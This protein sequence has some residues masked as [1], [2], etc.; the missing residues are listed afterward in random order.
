MARYRV[1]K[2]DGGYFVANRRSGKIYGWYP[3]SKEKAQAQAASME[4]WFSNKPRR[5]TR[6]TQYLCRKCGEKVATDAEDEK[7]ARRHFHTRA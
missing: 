5:H 6:W 4:T 3:R 1:I 7:A 2:G